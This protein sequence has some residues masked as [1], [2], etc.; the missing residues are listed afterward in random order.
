MVY[1]KVFQMRK[2]SKGR[3]NKL[4][5]RMQPAVWPYLVFVDYCQSGGQLVIGSL[6]GCDYFIKRELFQIYTW[7]GLG[8]C[9]SQLCVMYFWLNFSKGV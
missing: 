2:N 4:G 6:F 3:K 9:S 5:G 7:L 1:T 8:C